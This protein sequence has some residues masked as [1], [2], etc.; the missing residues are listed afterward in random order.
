MSKG[1]IPWTVFHLANGRACDFVSLRLAP[2][3]HWNVCSA[4]L[5]A[6]SSE[7]SWCPHTQR[8]ILMMTWALS[9]VLPIFQPRGGVPENTWSRLTGIPVVPNIQS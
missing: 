6:S 3:A 5:T 8:R 9:V 1:L 2:A 4:F 7:W